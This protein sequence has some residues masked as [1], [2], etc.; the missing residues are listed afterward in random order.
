M[1]EDTVM[2]K[3]YVRGS[4][5]SGDARK[6]Y[7]DVPW[8]AVKT[9]V[10]CLALVALVASTARAHAQTY[11]FATCDPA[12]TN[13]TPCSAT[14]TRCCYIDTSPGAS[15]NQ[16]GTDYA[17]VIPMDACHQ[18]SSAADDGGT[19]PGVTASSQ[20]CSKPTSG[21]DIF[22]VYGLMYRMM[23]VGIP[24]YWVINPS[25]DPPALGCTNPGSCRQ[26]ATDIDMWIMDAS[27]TMP[28]NAA[29]PLAGS[30]ASTFIKHWT[31]SSAGV[32]QPNAGWTYDKKQFPIRSSAFVIS[33]Q[34]RAKF[35]KMVRRQAPYDKWAANPSRTCGNGT[36]CQDFSGIEFFEIQPTASIGFT[37]FTTNTTGSP[38]A[39]AFY[40]GRMPVAAKLD[41]TPPRIANRPGPSGV[42]KKWL[43]KANLKDDADS[44]CGGST[45]FSPSDAVLCDLTV[46]EI[47]A[48]NLKTKNFGWL[49]LDHKAPSCGA[50]LTAIQDFLTASSTWTAGN[51]MA[52]ADGTSNEDCDGQ[53]L[54]GKQQSGSGIGTP[55][56]NAPGKYIYRYPANMMSQWGNVAADFAN[57]LGGAGFTV[58]GGSYGYHPNFGGAKNSLHRL[59]TVDVGTN[60]YCPYNKSI[61]VCDSLGGA[62]GETKDLAVYGRYLNGEANGIVYYLPGTQ[63]HNTAPELRM[64]L[65]SLL[66]IPLGIVSTTQS[67]IEVSRSAPI[68]A[69]LSNQNVV[70]Q[71]TYEVTNPLTVPSTMSVDAE[72]SAFT[73]PSTKGHLRAIAT[74]TS[75]STKFASSTEVFDAA[76]HIPPA[77]PSGCSQSFTSSCRTVFTT[78]ASGFRPTMTFLDTKSATVTAL[79]PIMASNL[80][81]TSRATLISRVLAGKKDGTSYV[82]ALGGVDRSTVAVIEASPVTGGVRPTIAY[83]GAADGML[84]AVCA[85]VQSGT[86]CDVVGRELWAYIPRTMLPYLRYNT[87]VVNGSPSVRDAFGDF[88]G[89]GLREWRTVLIFQT[90]MGDATAQARVPAVFAL[91]ITDPESPAVIW[92]YSLEDAANRGTY[93]LGAGLTI[94]AGVTMVNGTRKEL[95]WAQTNN[96]GTGGAGSVVTAIDL[97]TGKTVWTT[98]NRGYAY[99][100]PPRG[101]GG[102]TSIPTGGMPGGAVAVDRVG[103]GLV[104]DVVYADLYGNLWMI[105]PAT[106]ANRYGTSPLFAFTTN[107]HAIGAKPAI[108]SS[109]GVQYA[110]FVSGGFVDPSDT[111]WGS[112]VQQYVVS[113]SLNTPVTSAPLNENSSQHIGFKYAL[114]STT[115]KGYS[116]ALVVGNQIFVTTDTADVNATT[117]GVDG[118]ATGKLYALDFNGSATST[119]IVGGATSVARSENGI[120][121]GSS[122]T[123]Q[124]GSAAAPGGVGVDPEGIAR[125]SRMLWLRTQ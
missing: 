52:I 84:H 24:A 27:A 32:F 23:Q 46:P 94:A 1:N 125:V 112:G 3:E 53:Q 78:T 107:Y 122:T 87:A 55:N 26:I 51:V 7:V 101:V 93:E 16:S 61:G 113:V 64:L 36:S 67:V 63:I 39:T 92:E 15:F 10:V 45:T 110:V 124:Y 76:D 25:K 14:T 4:Y 80:N 47:V 90:G 98:P 57:G 49:W 99:A 65:N 103:N 6:P 33:A 28:P 108:Y 22:K 9:R 19:A 95:V 60:T 81:A 91:D 17:L 73:F 12:V 69:V 83:F 58:T 116:Q 100:V 119:V 2:T 97:E 21:S 104:T 59:V 123:I 106:G 5:P 68:A 29:A 118:S 70:V 20:W 120:Y 38:G 11:D 72:A 13:T 62:S 74:S 30:P 54:L 75:L 82:P 89:D 96:G 18:D 114:G 88:D 35:N 79:G 31:L 117:Y 115:E 40:A 37:D 43:E 42:S 48:G 109:N 50:E 41:Y 105:D 77:T 34:D 44:G 102:A 121:A 85:S 111:N 71:G 66:A 56:G 86:G 8:V